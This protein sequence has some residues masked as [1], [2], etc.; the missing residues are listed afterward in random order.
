MSEGTR[1]C[2]MRTRRYIPGRTLLGIVGIALLSFSSPSFAESGWTIEFLV[3]VPFSF[4]SSLTIRQGGEPDLRHRP[5]FAS[6]SFNPPLYYAVRIGKW[7]GSDGWELEMNHDKLYLSNPTREVEQFAISHGFNRITLNR[8]MERGDL[9]WRL[10]AGVVI[11][12]PENT[13]RG[14]RFPEEGGIL[15]MGYHLSGPTAMGAIGARIGPREG[16]FLT[17]E[18]M[19][20]ASWVRVPVAG[21]NA[22]FALAGVHG[23]LGAGYGW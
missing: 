19:G 15:G 21:G 23:L 22:D 7:D 11:T 12:H 13:V 20:T 6:R 8:T 10:G 4:P 9:V 14:R 3:G 18:G 5:R 2:R 17:P 1:V 16:P